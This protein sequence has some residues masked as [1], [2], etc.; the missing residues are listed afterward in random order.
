M[1]R[2]H[3]DAVLGRF[4]AGMQRDAGLER[5]RA[6]LVESVRVSHCVCLCDPPW[7][8]LSWRRVQA[9]YQHRRSFNFFFFL[10]RNLRKSTK[11]EKS[12]AR[13]TV[14]LTT[15]TADVSRVWFIVF[16]G[17]CILTQS[18]AAS[19]W[20]LSQTN[21]SDFIGFLSREMIEIQSLE[22][23]NRKISSSRK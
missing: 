15:E 13:R 17:D 3:R 7:L 2:L 10:V 1:Y 11:N 21:M 22:C 5:E 19:L 14:Q 20:R 16:R 23:T 6:R 4:R 18:Y 12:D 8:D 9:L